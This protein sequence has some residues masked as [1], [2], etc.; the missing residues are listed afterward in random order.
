MLHSYC[1]AVKIT[2]TK[3]YCSWLGSEDHT[4]VPCA[5]GLDPATGYNF[6]D[7][8]LEAGLPEP[9]MNVCSPLGGGPD[10]P[11]YD[12]GVE[13]LRSML[14]LI[15]KLGISAEE[16]VGIDTLADGLR[17]EVAASVGVI[18]TPDLVGAWGRK[19]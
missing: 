19:R 15:V 13:S 6:R 14:P 2:G 10:F 18:K 9:E 11:G 17:T 8:F 16:E 3:A 7:T 1:N 5:A 4:F 12:Y